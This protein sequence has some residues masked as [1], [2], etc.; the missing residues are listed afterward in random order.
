MIQAPSVAERIL[1]V[2]PDT[3]AAAVLS[4]AL[5]KAGYET[6]V[7]QS[8]ESALKEVHGYDA[9]VTEHALEGMSG[10]RLVETLHQRVPMLPVLM[11]SAVVES[12]L[13][14]KAVQAGAYDFLAK[15]A[16]TDELL[17][18]LGEALASAKEMG[19]R[20]AASP[21]SEGSDVLIGNSR[22]MMKVYREVAKLAAT[23]VTVL[24]RGETGTGKELIARGLY[25][26]GHRAH[27]PFFAVN[28]AAIPPE[29]LESELFGHEKGAFTGALKTRIGRF[30]MAHGATLF[31]DEIGDMD[32][33]LQAKLLR[34]LQE[35]QIQRVGSQTDIPTD[36]RF[37]AATHQDLEKMVDEGR[38]RQDLFY[39][40][41]G[42]TIDLPPLRERESDISQLVDHFLVHYGKELGIDEPAITSEAVAL[43]TDQPFPGN[44]RQL[45][46]ILRR[47]LIKRRG[48]VIGLGDIRELL[49]EEK[50]D[51][52]EHKDSLKRLA[53]ELVHQAKAGER[54]DIH[55]S[56][57]QAAESAIISEALRQ[58]GGNQAQVSRWLGITRY[59]LREKMKSFQIKKSY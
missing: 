48:Y 41:N 10:L 12:T 3:D 28:C 2:D 44:I 20:V 31:L 19:R 16:D 57:V 36:V 13:T 18:L 30:E 47:A 50:P 17:D 23:P 39:R 35:K 24:I 7:K 5:D 46:N 34:V 22:A 49:D 32:L 9:V 1:I 51:A 29:L 55:R 53:E 37:I 21:D 4:A 8:G 40:L 14:I 27:K 59:T 43:L 45:Q 56:I 15:P 42:A 25:Q 33:A 58:A 11:I 38:F 54:T 6:A 52:T 26:H